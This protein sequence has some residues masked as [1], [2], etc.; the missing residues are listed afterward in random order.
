MHACA[1]VV[2]TEAVGA[3]VTPVAKEALL[4]LHER[5]CAAGS[6]DKVLPGDEAAVLR[7]LIWLTAGVHQCV[8]EPSYR[9]PS[10]RP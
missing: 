10:P 1:Q 5:I 8:T 9:L 4:H 2:C 6:Q 7:C 3:G